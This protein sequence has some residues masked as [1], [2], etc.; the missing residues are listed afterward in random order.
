MKL[1]VID[2]GDESTGI[3]SAQYSVDAPFEDKAQDV[4]SLDFFRDGI[5]AL[6]AEFALWDVTAMYDFEIEAE[7]ERWRSLNNANEQEPEHQP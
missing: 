3:F 7:D 6:F 5:I 2:H 1:I 4:E